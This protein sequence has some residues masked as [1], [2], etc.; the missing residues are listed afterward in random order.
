MPV[1]AVLD[2]GV[3]ILVVVVLTILVLRVNP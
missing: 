3:M 1:D 2:H